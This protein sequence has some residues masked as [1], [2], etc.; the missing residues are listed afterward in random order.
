MVQLIKPHHVQITTKEGEVHVHLTLDIN[1]NLAG[2]NI[3]STQQGSEPAKDEDKV[4]WEVPEF[5]S[6]KVKF[7]K[8]D[9]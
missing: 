7:G 1:L 8:G 3:G 5:T 9:K 6:S 2:V 4:H